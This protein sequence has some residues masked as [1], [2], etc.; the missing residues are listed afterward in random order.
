MGSSLEKLT[1]LDLKTQQQIINLLSVGN[2]ITVACK[3]AGITYR[4]FRHWQKRWE[5]GDPDAMRFDEF[6]QA[7]YQATALGESNAL[8]RLQAGGPS[9]QAQAW[10]LERRFH[11]RW[12]RKD[13]VPDAPKPPK[14]SKPIR[15]M[16][17]DEFNA[18]ERE[19]AEYDRRYGTGKD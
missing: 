6:F 16:S 15:D 12:G 11:Q 8:I 18:Y 1:A 13:R 4:G 2:Y 14:P 3:A 19:V 7:V 17:R 9:W 10:F 5:E